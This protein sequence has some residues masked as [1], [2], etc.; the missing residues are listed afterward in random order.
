MGDLRLISLPNELLHY[1]CLFLS[2]EDAIALCQTCLHFRQALNDN[3]V[4]KRFV[5]EEVRRLKNQEQLLSPP[6]QPDLTLCENHPHQHILRKNHL[7]SNWRNGKFVQYEANHDIQNMMFTFIHWYSAKVYKENYLFVRHKRDIQFWDISGSPILYHTLENDHRKLMGNCLV[8]AGERCRV[9]VYQINIEERAFPSLY[10]FS[11]VE[12]EVVNEIVLHDQAECCHRWECGQAG[13]YLVFNQ[14]S[15]DDCF[16]AIHIWD[17]ANACKVGV[18]TSPV[19]CCYVTYPR[20]ESDCLFLTTEGSGES[21][22]LKFDITARRFSAA[23]FRARDIY[24]ISYVIFHKN[25]C[26]V[27]KRREKKEDGEQKSLVCEVFDF[28]SSTKV[29]ERTFEKAEYC[30]QQKHVVDGKLVIFNPETYH[31]VDALT[32]DTVFVVPHGQDVHTIMCQTSVFGSIFLVTIE[33]DGVIKVWDMER[34]RSTLIPQEKLS[35]SMVNHIC[36]A[37]RNRAITYGKEP[38]TKFVTFG[39]ER[40][41]VTHFW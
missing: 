20:L 22:Y 15:F 27:M 36:Y 1:L 18:F 31:V 11:V 41:C 3:I 21:F 2:K 7:I 19:R 37:F 6:L 10:S 24:N 4:W 9:D 39:K 14:R 33:S 28:D 5:T 16:P 34:K 23:A 12:D 8:V 40:M 13:N 17:I 32:L 25:H 29:R 38:L 26:I 35:D 30:L